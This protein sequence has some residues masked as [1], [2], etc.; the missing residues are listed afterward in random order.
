VLFVDSSQQLWVYTAAGGPN[1]ALRPT[2][3]RVAYHGDGIFTLTGK[4]LNGQSAGSNYGDDSESDE[5]FPIVR[6][7]SPTGAVYYCRTANWST[8][9]VGGGATLETVNFTLNREVQAGNYAL[10]VVGAGIPSF[11]VFVNITENEVKGI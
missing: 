4:E 7:T 1:P 11:P 6:L 9:G 10:N 5:N 2:V 3:N 8:V